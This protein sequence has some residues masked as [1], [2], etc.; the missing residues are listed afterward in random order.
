M[1]G[2][3]A[4]NLDDSLAAYDLALSAY[5]LNGCS[6]LHN[7]YLKNRSK[8]QDTGSIRYPANKFLLV[9]VYDPPTR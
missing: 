6:Y 7:I 5:F 9:P 8:T 3:D 1:F 4:P 2:I